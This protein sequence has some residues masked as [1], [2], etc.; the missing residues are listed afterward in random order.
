MDATS[1]T[2][3]PP[4]PIARGR[5]QR[6][7]KVLT[8]GLGLA[9]IGCW[10]AP[11]AARLSHPSLLTD[12]V[13]RVILLQRHPTV[14]RLFIPFNEHLAP[15]FAGVATIAWFA[16]GARL[17]SVPT[18]FAW[19]GL[20]PF[21]LCLPSLFAW[22]RAETGSTTTGWAAT[23]LFAGTPAF[24]EAV[25]WHAASSFCWALLPTL[26][27]LTIA[28]RSDGRP[29]RRDQFTLMCCCLIAPMGSA[30]GL[31][32][33]PAVMARLVPWEMP[34]GGDLR[35]WIGRCVRS[36]GPMLG[37]LGF[38]AIGGLFGLDEAV[39]SSTRGERDLVGGLVRAAEAPGT[40][41]LAGFL[42]SGD[43]AASRF[44]ATGLQ[45]LSAAGALAVLI[46]VLRGRTDDRARL[47]AA[48][49]LIALP[50]VLISCARVHVVGS[51]TL[52][53]NTRYHLFPTAGLVMLFGLAGARWLRRLDAR[54][55]GSRAAVL[56]LAA[57]MVLF[58]ATAFEHHLG[59]F[60][61]RDQAGT[62]RALDRLA[63]EARGLG[64]ARD[65]VVQA[66][67][68]VIPRWSF[69]GGNVLE[70][71][72]ETSPAGTIDTVGPDVDVRSLLLSRLAVEDR[73]ALLAGLDASAYL[74][75]SPALGTA[76]IWPRT[77]T[78]GR[79]GQT[80]NMAPEPDGLPGRYQSAGWP[81]FIEFE[82]GEPDSSATPGPV[83]LLLPRIEAD[84]PL[85]VWWRGADGSWSSALSVTLDPQSPGPVR[86]RLSDLP[87]W[88]GSDARAVR[89]VVPRRGPI[90]I[91]AP[92]LLR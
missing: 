36:S 35:S 54:P 68:P 53:Q 41:L 58:H 34:K 90:A 71:L 15:L 7:R 44:S 92:T 69:A 30:V 38:L 33:G 85:Q 79:V 9:I 23:T 88:D 27:A 16:G 72:P 70:L 11:W 25:T 42:G 37:T 19:A 40:L 91:E 66:F 59:I 39:S 64:I 17:E 55:L 14:Q 13:V 89:L 62:L 45:L 26:V 3:G 18:A 20:L 10:V 48:S 2:T 50:Y 84:Q 5:W 32:A 57:G 49:A 82:F 52:W 60:R 73:S 83:S 6:P 43:A 8:I 75:E 56:G 81:G 78:L 77:A 67:D 22:I 29:G 28:A 46:A 65:R 63:V 61:F 87:H 86:L 51:G 21:L 1:T 12:D 80:R 24:A 74:D 76:D 47:M 4:G 31:F